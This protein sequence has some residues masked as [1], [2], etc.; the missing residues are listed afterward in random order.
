M[1]IDPQW[2]PCL[3]VA[4]GVSFSVMA[5]SYR[6]GA[7]RRVT[8][9]HILLIAC[10]MGM[11]VFGSQSLSQWGQLPLR[12][13]GLA[14]LA[15]FSQYLLLKLMQSALKHGPLSPMWCALMLGFIPVIV[16][17]SVAFGETLELKH[18]L[19][20]GTAT[21]SVLSA[22]FADWIVHRLRGGVKV[23]REAA[24]QTDR[25]LHRTLRESLLYGALLMAILVTNAIASIAVKELS[26]RVL[27]D[28]GTAP[29]H[30]AA[31][32]MDEFRY[33]Y[34][35]LL[36]LF[37]EIGIV[38]ELAA[39]KA[40]AAPSRSVIGLGV[41]AGCGTIAGMITLTIYSAG[42]AAALFPVAG[43]SSIVATS[44]GSVLL[45]GEKMSPGWLLS[46]GLGIATV[47][48]ASV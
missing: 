16:Y 47:I 5:I 48:I 23:S 31:S 12:V 41:L 11:A 36:Y 40:P 27:P 37:I 26:T 33:A 43:V 32:Y 9:T 14:M 24:P 39:S 34:L 10:A 30:A 42:H 13:V 19:A 4:S 35:F 20:I 21:A 3:A 8:P 29:T 18:C 38:I 44:V 46:V 28:A 45:F 22:A 1:Q 25:H 17:A 15:G 2:M 7:P 6:V